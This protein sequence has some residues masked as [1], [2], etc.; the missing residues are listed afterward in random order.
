[1]TVTRTIRA[2]YFLN[3]GGM[4]LPLVAALITVPI[5]IHLIGAARYGVLSIVWLLLGYFGFLD[6]GLSRASA[7]ALSRLSHENAA[8]RVPVLVTSLYLNMALGLFGGLVLYGASS[9]LLAYAGSIPDALRPEITSAMP[10]IATMLPIALISAVGAG[11]LE[12]RERF[13][14]ANVLTTLSGVV[15]QVAPVTCA[16]F[17]GPTLEVV[18]PAAF[19]ARLLSTVLVWVLVAHIERPLDLRRFDRSRVR[20]LLGYGAWVSVTSVISPLLETLDQVLIGA[21]LGPASVAHYTVPMSLSTRCLVVSSALAKTL[22]PRL[23]RLGRDD[24][25]LLAERATMLLAYAFAGVCG[26]AIIIAGPFLKLWVGPDFAAYSIPVA[27]ILLVGA[28]CNGVAYIPYTLLQGQGR[29]DLTARI[30]LAEILPFLALLW[31]LTTQFGLPGAALA[32]TIRVA[33]DWVVLMLVSGFR[34]SQLLHFVPPTIC[35]AACWAIAGGTDL[36]LPGAMA[37]AACVGLVLL[38]AALRLNPVAYGLYAEMMPRRLRPY[39][40]GR[41]E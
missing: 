2:N 31:L 29:P 5:Y 6:F 17:F 12:S 27:H 11:A 33:A 35:L 4:V 37:L 21:M 1:M 13:M 26:P 34:K 16:W 25:T 8:E 32:W 19:L 36:T 10:W 41:V 7:N 9:L 14:E 38:V 39:L 23:S 3:V 20:G 30:H 28:W 22:F 40:L 18:I 24:A 15:G